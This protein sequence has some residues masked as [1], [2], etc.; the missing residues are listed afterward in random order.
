MSN[1]IVV[2]AVRKHRCDSDCPVSKNRDKE[3][4]PLL[5]HP[6]GSQASG[7]THA[8]PVASRGHLRPRPATAGGELPWRSLSRLLSLQSR[9]R[10]PFSISGDMMQAA[11]QL[12]KVALQSHRYVH[13]AFLRP[14]CSGCVWREPWCASPGNTVSYLLSSQQV[15]A[16]CGWRP[17][18][19]QASSKPGMTLQRENSPLMRGASW[20]GL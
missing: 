15:P 16:A 8:E 9:S 12:E 13:R 4:C 14:V 3:A 18:L 1:A 11:V 7:K 10:G 20:P 19:P 5:V 2:L 17:G 6:G